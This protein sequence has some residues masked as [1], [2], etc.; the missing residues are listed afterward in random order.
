MNPEARGKEL[1]M[2]KGGFKLYTRVPQSQRGP[3]GR[4]AP[5]VHYRPQKAPPPAWEVWYHLVRRLIR[6]LRTVGA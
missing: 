4:W 2:A 3:G 5:P 1:T 6:Y